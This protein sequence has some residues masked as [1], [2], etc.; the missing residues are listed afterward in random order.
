MKPYDGQRQRYYLVKLNKDAKIDINT[1]HTP[2]FSQYKF[3]ETKNIY[4]YITFFK[5]TVYKQVLKY[6]KKEGYI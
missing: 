4:D 5:R 6:F 2:E 1:H 3:V